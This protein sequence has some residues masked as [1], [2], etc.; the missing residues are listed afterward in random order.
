ML[1]GT[2]ATPNTD[3]TGWEETGWVA[4]ESARE[5]LA[6]ALDGMV[7]DKE[8]SRTRAIEIAHMVLRDNAKRLYGI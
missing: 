5:A 2:D 3:A 7:Q 6:I 1:F 8:I 4:T